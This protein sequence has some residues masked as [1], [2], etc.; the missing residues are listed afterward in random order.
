MGGV[1]S[2]LMEKQT[3]S[4]RNALQGLYYTFRNERNFRIHLVSGLVVYFLAWV[5]KLSPTE[6]AILTLTVFLVL[7]VE[8]VNTTIEALVDRLAEG[9]HAHFAKISKDVAA[10]AVLTTSLGAALVGLLIFAPKI[11]S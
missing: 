3:E 7:T 4:F 10:A 9:E 8:L 5:Y 1:E 6:L 11:F 2:T